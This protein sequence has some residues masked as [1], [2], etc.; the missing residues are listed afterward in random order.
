[1]QERSQVVK[2]N[3]APRREEKHGKGESGSLPTCERAM[4][5]RSGQNKKKSATTTASANGVEVR[6]KLE[7]VTERSQERGEG[8]VGRARMVP[9]GPT[10]LAAP[11]TVPPEGRVRVSVRTRSGRAI[12]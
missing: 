11:G 9:P 4:Q 2:I 3:V 7:Q 1:M 5:R 12:S 8:G 6:R 10:P